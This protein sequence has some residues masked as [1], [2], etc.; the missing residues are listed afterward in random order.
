[1]ANTLKLS[2]NLDSTLKHI[3]SML[4]FSPDTVFST[5]QT[6]TKS[7]PLCVSSTP[8]SSFEKLRF[9]H[10][11]Q[12]E[13]LRDIYIQYQGNP[14]QS[15]VNINNVNS[16]LLSCKNKEEVFSQGSYKNCL[17]NKKR[18]LPKGM[19]L[20]GIFLVDEGKNENYLSG[21]WTLAL[22]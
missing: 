18:G 20:L 7:F 5:S 15:D 17:K 14:A 12:I 16:I 1:M 22:T 2:V 21:L 4:P 10:V 3:T 8:L 6:T 11:K 13:Q 19:A 9:K